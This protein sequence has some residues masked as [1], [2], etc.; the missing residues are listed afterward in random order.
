[1]FDQAEVRKQRVLG[2]IYSKLFWVPVMLGTS[3]GLLGKAPWSWVGWTAV[4][5]GVGSVVWRTTVGGRELAERAITRVKRKSSREHRAYLRQLQRKLRR[6]RDERTGEMLRSL[7]DLY[8]RLDDMEFDPGAQQSWQINIFGQIRNLYQASLAA[9]ERS[10]EL[11]NRANEMTTDEARK[12]LLI[13]RD[14][15][16]QE[17]KQSVLQL[18]KT[19]DDVQASTMKRELPDEDLTRMRAELEQGLKVAHEI[20]QQMEQL[21]GELKGLRVILPEPS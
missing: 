9:L 2:A 5:L 21:E 18:S 11:W 19:V 16:L 12:E 7:R 17:V 1:M 10:Y 14:S 3:L 15:V 8:G 20:E 4:V 6:D 13:W